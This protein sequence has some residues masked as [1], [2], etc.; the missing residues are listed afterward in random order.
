MAVTKNG[1]V[2]VSENAHHCISVSVCTVG[3]ERRSDHFGSKGSSTG[4]FQYP[5]GVAITSDNHILVADE[6][7]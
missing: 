1:E 6:G 4:Q 5:R 3:R 7:L 2:I